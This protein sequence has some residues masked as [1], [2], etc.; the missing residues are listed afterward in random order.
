MGTFEIFRRNQLLFLEA[1]FVHLNA[2]LSGWF[3]PI[4]GA[5]F[6]FVSV[7]TYFTL[8]FMS[9][10]LSQEDY[11]FDDFVEVLRSSGFPSSGKNFLMGILSVIFTIPLII[12]YNLDLQPYPLNSGICSSIA[13]LIGA[14]VFLIGTAN[15][16]KTG[17]VLIF[18]LVGLP[19]TVVSLFLGKR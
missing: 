19:V 7:S 5:T 1:G 12:F 14:F 16:K 2:I 18:S 3:L 6:I 13:C 8:C 4:W 9:S 17:A 15:W 10:V 11:V